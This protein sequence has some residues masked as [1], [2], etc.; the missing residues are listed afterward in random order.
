ME[1]EHCHWCQD[2]K[3]KGECFAGE[4]CTSNNANCGTPQAHDVPCGNG[5]NI[6]TRD[7]VASLLHATLYNELPFQEMKDEIDVYLKI[8]S[9]LRD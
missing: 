7:Y 9:K 1:P 4:C 6:S 3:C 5:E 2:D 8:A